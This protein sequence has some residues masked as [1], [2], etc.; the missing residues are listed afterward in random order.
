MFPSC[1]ERHWHW[2]L[3]G[4]S[5][6]V[7]IKRDIRFLGEYPFIHCSLFMD[8]FKHAKAETFNIVPFWLSWSSSALEFFSTIRCLIFFYDKWSIYMAL[9]QC[10]SIVPKCSKQPDLH[11][12]YPSHCQTRVRTLRYRYLVHTLWQDLCAWVSLLKNGGKHVLVR[13][14][15]LEYGMISECAQSLLRVEF[16]LEQPWWHCGVGLSDLCWADL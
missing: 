14:Y 1:I 6:N 2:I 8:H 9:I 10:A 7:K 16:D 3:K 11:I 4:S 5:E 15:T 13:G 12:H